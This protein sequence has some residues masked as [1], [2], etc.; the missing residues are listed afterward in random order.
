MFDSL[1]T[2][3]F[4]E[5]KKKEWWIS[6]VSGLLFIFVSVFYFIIACY[7]LTYAPLCYD[8]AIEFYYSLHLFSAEV[9]G[10][11]VA[12]MYQRIISTF[13]PPLY[14][15]LMFF[16]LKINQSEWWFRFAGVA[17]GYI[18]MLGVYHSVRHIVNYKYATIAALMYSCTYEVVFYIRD[19]G[20]YNLLL[21]FLPWT[22]YFF[23]CVLEKKSWNSIILFIIFSVLPI[24]SQ[25]GAI[26]VVIPMLLLVF[27]DTVF[28]KD[29]KKLKKL[30]IGYI[31]AF[32]F[33]AIPLYVFFLKPQIAASQRIIANKV[34]D[35]VSFI[36]NTS[37]M[38]FMK[39]MFDCFK[40]HIIGGKLGNNPAIVPILIILIFLL[41]CLSVYLFFISKSKISKNL[42]YLNCISAGL[43]YI[44]AKTKIY[45]YPIYAWVNW[46]S[47]TNRYSF[48]FIPI[49]II[50]IT[51]FI[52]FF[53]CSLPKSDIKRIMIKIIFVIF[54]LYC[55]FGTLNIASSHGIKYGSNYR[56]LV[57]EWFNLKCYESK[58]IIESWNAPLFFYYLT[59]H[60]D[61][62]ADMDNDIILCNDREKD[63]RELF[64][65]SKKIT[66][67]DRYIY[68]GKNVEFIVKSIA[69]S[70][71]YSMKTVYIQYEK[72]YIFC[73]E[74]I[75][76]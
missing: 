52:Y 3:Q 12:N 55:I 25:Y 50:S 10:Y 73:K 74:D 36:H 4:A 56:Q 32:T 48:F 9:P 27:I 46:N 40:Y 49:W 13:Q 5:L 16:W 22:I 8:E 57:N 47:F 39:N 59:K 2:I 65:E 21:V 6:H 53:I 72:F 66:Y 14:N 26:F 62:V 51:I 44:A 75:S 24:Y 35:N 58:T 41:F 64:N 17:V 7:K 29:W 70:C 43:F 76:D 63:L 45:A 67:I 37:L 69:E 30:S 42:I 19:C 18:G 60:K 23:L 68:R 11:G 1:R 38:D 33:T 28:S 15:F 54:L 31:C 34:T 20:E 61:Y 71:N